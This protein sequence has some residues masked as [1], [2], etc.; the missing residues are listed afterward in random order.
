MALNN[1]RL[2]QKNIKSA[3]PLFNG[4]LA[5]SLVLVDAAKLKFNANVK[6]FTGDAGTPFYEFVASDENGKPKTFG[7]IDDVVSWL[8][9]AYLDITAL[10]F[11]VGG[12]DLISKTFEPP[13]DPVK[14]ATAQKARFT[15]LRDGIADNLAKVSALV[16][17]AVASGWDLPTAHP[18][19]QAN[20]AEYVK[21]QTAVTAIR[22]FYVA[23]IARYNAIIN[24]A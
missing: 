1:L 23:E 5:V 7:D 20:Y 8:R 24:P 17:A 21:Q 10:T 16:T 2:A 13:L 22:D 6:A 14:D 18:A 11:D 3:N 19:L 12:M 15:K 9:G 4:V